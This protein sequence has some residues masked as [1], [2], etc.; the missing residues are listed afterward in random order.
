MGL[1]KRGSRRSTDE[2]AIA[3]SRRSIA[4]PEVPAGKKRET[5]KLSVA[6][7]DWPIMSPSRGLAGNGDYRT[8]VGT[9]LPACE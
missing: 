9:R 2:M 7:A 8:P 1:W 6:V 3:T 5:C 4:L